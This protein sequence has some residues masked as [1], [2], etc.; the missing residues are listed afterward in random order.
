MVL[1]IEG[2]DLVRFMEIG[3][4]VMIIWDVEGTGYGELIVLFSIV[5]ILY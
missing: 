5:V 1:F 4:R 2:F 3:S